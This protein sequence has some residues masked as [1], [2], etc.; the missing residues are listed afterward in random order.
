M[1]EISK[2][3]KNAV[4][5]LNCFSRSTPILGVSELS[6]KLKLPRTNVLRLLATLE[7]FGFIEKHGDGSGYHIGLRT[8]EIGSLYLSASP[9][10]SLLTRALD[11]LVETTQCTAYLA[12]LDQDDIIILNYRAGTLPIRFIWQVGDRLPCATT[13][14]GKAILAHMSP[15]EIDKHLGKGQK[16]RGLTKRSLRTRKE[17]ERDLTDARKRGWGLA[18]EESHA[19]LTAVGSAILDEAGHPI[20]AISISFFDYP[21]QRDRLDRFGTIVRKVAENVS[22]RIAE[23]AKYGVGK[24]REELIRHA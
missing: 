21:P 12:V 18:R 4:S 8:F 11:E 14:S 23:S 6:R 1:P 15:A 16:L 7:A 2:T 17:L 24:S 20:A 13:S 9:L 5:L 22:K 19:A 10:S 3:V